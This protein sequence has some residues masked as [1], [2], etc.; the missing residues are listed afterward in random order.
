MKVRALMVG[1]FALFAS[2]A[3]GQSYVG[4]IDSMN[5][6][7][8]VVNVIA[9][10]KF[11][12]G[13]AINQRFVITASHCLWEKGAYVKKVLVKYLDKD[14]VARIAQARLSRVGE[15]YKKA[16]AA[17]DALDGKIDKKSLVTPR[18]VAL[19]IRS[20]SEDVGFI[21]LEDNL[22]LVSYP[23]TIFNPKLP[24]IAFL[25]S[26]DKKKAWTPPLITKAVA[27]L[28]QALL[29]NSGETSAFAVGYGRFSCSDWNDEKSC[30]PVD[31]RR[32]FGT[33]PLVPK[34][35]YEAENERLLVL[36]TTRLKSEV[37]PIQPGDSGGGIFVKHPLVKDPVLIGI[38][39]RRTS[40][41]AFEASLLHHGWNLGA[42]MSSKEYKQ[43]MSETPTAAVAIGRTGGPGKLARIS[44]GVG[45]DSTDAKARQ[46]A[47]G[48]CASSGMR[49]CKIV[50][51]TQKGCLYVALGALGAEV[52]YKTG[53][54]PSETLAQ[55]R[56]GGFQCREPIGGCI[57]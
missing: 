4:E 27:L 34:W 33:L 50:T 41:H 1:L 57:Q 15:A 42:F 16:A 31:G 12:T 28:A 35:E 2:T 10:G 14:S 51:A 56:K 7:S 40:E 45:L 8:Y 3:P 11:C 39:A 21:L 29:P 38:I 54:T 32:R 23:A 53:A 6:Y 20:I 25:R 43:A 18:E 5:E 46:V 47:L 36:M 9:D 55:C 26:D 48:Q 44:V 49:G 52:R 19:I 24:F 37:N 22:S 17:A 30:Q 13:V